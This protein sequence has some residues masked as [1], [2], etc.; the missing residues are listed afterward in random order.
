MDSDGDGIPDQVDSTPFGGG[1]FD[2]DRIQ[3]IEREREDDLIEARS[4]RYQQNRNGRRR[5]RVGDEKDWASDVG[6]FT[7]LVAL[8][9]GA[10]VLASIFSGPALTIAALVATGAAFAV[11]QFAKYNPP[12]SP[13]GNSSRSDIDENGRTAPERERTRTRELLK[14][15]S[16]THELGTLSPSIT[17]NAQRSNVISR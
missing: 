11:L 3:D 17:P 1:D 6:T 10:A 12:Q 16:P 15:S 8:G 2:D 4:P 14:N 13:K 5:R 9:V 7:G